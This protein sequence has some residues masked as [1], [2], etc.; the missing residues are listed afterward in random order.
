MKLKYVQ[1][2]SDD[3][4]S[5]GTDHRSDDRNP[6]VTPIGAALT[7]NRQNGMGQTRTEVTGGVHRVPRRT[8]KAH[9][10]S[11]DEYTYDIGPEASRNLAD[12]RGKIIQMTNIKKKDAI[13]SQRKLAG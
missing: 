10:Q 7:G 12:S 5:E 1:C 13:N 3:V 6:S 4:G 8:A 11:P 2:C 9:T